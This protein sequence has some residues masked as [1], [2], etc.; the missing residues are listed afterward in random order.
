MPKV[1]HGLARE[2]ATLGHQVSIMARTFP[3]QPDEERDGDVH[4]VRTRGFAQSASLVRDLAKDFAYAANLLRRLPPADILVS[5]DFWVPALVPALR[6]S[7][8]ATVVCAARFPKGQYRLY[9]RVAKVVA[10]STAVRTAIVGE[11]PR[12]ADKTVVIPLPV[13][14]AAFVPRDGRSSS[15]GKRTLLYVG[16][17]HPEKGI[18]LLLRSFAL[19]AAHLTHWRLKI[20]GPEADADG[21]GGEAFARRM[22]ELARGLDVDFRGPVFD[23]AAL[24]TEY[25]EADLFCYP[26]LA[27]RGE[28]FGLAPLESMAC[29][30][31][32]IVSALQCFGD[33]VRD[34]E[35]GWIFDHRARDAD[36]RLAA[37]LTQAMTDDAVRAR[38]GRRAE[39]DARAFTY[40]AVAQRYLDEFGRILASR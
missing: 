1:W 28:A 23:Q 21:G 22:R 3:G 19:A 2:F 36:A 31:P 33:F 37:A 7:A 12:M 24:A 17:V 34:R 35:N 8:G 16:R 9:P 30:V 6:R 13:D 15:D 5:N 38:L 39:T 10:I 18:E 32:P 29:D 26:S 14:V 27:E 25:R 40:A 20:V 4:I 11:Q